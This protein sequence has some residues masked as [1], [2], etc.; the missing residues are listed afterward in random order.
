VKR[1]TV[2]VYL[3]PTR[4]L[5]PNLDEG[6]PAHKLLQRWLFNGLIGR[7]TNKAAV[8]AIGA[9]ER[10]DLAPLVTPISRT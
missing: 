2:Q 3:S 4:K 6:V 1:L 10:L 9:V 8:R 7:T 5:D